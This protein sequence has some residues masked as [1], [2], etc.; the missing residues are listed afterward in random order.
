MN[1]TNIKL[2]LVTRSKYEQLAASHDATD[3]ELAS[4]RARAEYAQA[5]DQ[6]V[7]ENL[8]RLLENALNKNKTYET[9][10]TELNAHV[11]S[12]HQRLDKNNLELDMFKRMTT[13]IQQLISL[14]IRS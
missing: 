6:Q 3:S 7:I 11:D 12:L 4:L 14:T 9:L 1:L 5:Q 8:R 2:P 13:G 10:V